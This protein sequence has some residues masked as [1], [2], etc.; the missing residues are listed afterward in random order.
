VKTIWWYVAVAEGDA[1]K[2]EGTQM[3]SEDYEST[4]LDAD[5]ALQRLS[6]DT[7][8]SVVSRALEVI[9]NGPN[10]WANRTVS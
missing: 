10:A 9:H 5:V 3:E 7:Q 2:V 6:L 4:F 8:R 1:A